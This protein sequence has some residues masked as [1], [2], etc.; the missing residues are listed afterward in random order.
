MD[1]NEIPPQ[2][3]ENLI[4][5]SQHPLTWAETLLVDPVDRKPFKA[6]FAQKLL[7]NSK[8]KTTYLCVH[9]RA[10]KCLVGDSAVID[11][12]TLV[13]VPIS[14]AEGV[15]NTL[16]FDFAQ[17]KLVKTPCQWVDSGEKRCLR[18]HLGNG[19]SIGLSE[20]HLVFS[21]SKGWIQA[22]EL[23]VGDRILGPT[24]IGFFGENTATADQLEFYKDTTFFINSIP[25]E[26]YSLD[27][28]ALSNFLLELWQTKGGLYH[29]QQLAV[30]M[31]WSLN[32]AK[33]LQFLLQKYG[34][35]SVVDE[36]GNLS[37]RDSLEIALLLRALQIESPLYDAKSPRRWEIVIEIRKIGMQ[38]VY[39]LCVEHEDHNFVANNLIVHNSFIFSLLALW[40]ACCHEGKT[41][42]IYASSAFQVG[43]VFRKIDDWIFSN[44]L[45]GYLQAKA[46][47][48]RTPQ[49]R[50]F[51]TGSKI[52]GHIMGVAQNEKLKGGKRGGTA[53]I[54]FVDEAQEL[55][56]ED[57]EVIEP[58][59]QGGLYRNVK[60]YVAGTIKKPMGKFFDR[61]KKLGEDPFNKVIFVPVTENPDYTPE[62]LEETRLSTTPEIWYT[63]WL[64]EVGETDESVFRKPDV[65]LA[66]AYDWEYGEENIREGSFRVIGVDWDKVQAGSNIVVTQYE[67]E[68]GNF[69]IIYR[70][71]I[72]SGKFTYTNAVARILELISIYTPQFV[73]CDAGHGS[74]QWE[75]LVIEAE[76]QGMGMQDRI[77]S[78]AFNTKIELPNPQTGETER[79]LIKPFLVKLLDKKLQ[80]RRFFFPS[81]DEE[82]RNQFLTYKIKKVTENT[83]KFHSFREHIIDC[84]S[85][86]MYAIFM[87]FENELADWFNSNETSGVQLTT[88]ELN[89][90]HA[91]SEDQL[92]MNISSYN[93]QL[94]EGP[95]VFRS[96]FDLG[97]GGRNAF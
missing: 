29:N 75:T 37:I 81:S 48:S 72:E 71:E 70:E 93:R 12:D 18:V 85:L 89:T 64:L 61:V 83:I 65:D 6:N 50:S 82:T 80:A 7:L 27:K 77:L 32:I 45:L 55:T 44:E 94:P 73:V 36:D 5:I 1:L 62:K 34:V 28:G 17:N 49:M 30:F 23:K 21:R 92:L 56:T 8:K 46:G 40:W 57:W 26:V 31:L 38:R 16:C 4:K 59:M 88:E 69:T 84:C 76:K 3:R 22:K 67:H 47:N 24:E 96:D 66:A 39:D 53:D 52:F 58:I 2:A 13:P 33:Q 35:S 78:L 10:G 42:Y 54:V 41:I 20:D 15:K 51:T 74:M 63:E 14:R 68:T 25:D 43:E 60:S 19:S 97:L 11:A 79:K 9:R 95:G 86:C 91:A 87:Y 90:P